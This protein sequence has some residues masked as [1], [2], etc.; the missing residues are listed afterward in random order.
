QIP[1][2]ISTAVNVRVGQ[3][4]GAF[5]PSAAKFTYFTALTAIVIITFLTAAPVVM[6]RHSIPFIFTSDV[7]VAAKATEI[8]PMLFIFQLCEGL[9]VSL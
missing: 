5:N 7:E 1:L 6:L 8:L 3:G 9:A 2:G 4:L